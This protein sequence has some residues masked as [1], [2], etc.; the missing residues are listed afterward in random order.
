MSFFLPEG[1][2]V[3]GFASL[4]QG[5]HL[6]VEFALSSH[7][8]LHEKAGLLDPDSQILVRKPFPR[9]PLLQGLVIDDFF[10]ISAE[11]P[12]SDVSA[13]K[14]VEA[15]KIAKQ[16]Y[17]RENLL[18]SDEKDL[19]SSDHFQVT[20]AEVNSSHKNRSQHLVSVSAP[21]GKRLALAALSLRVASFPG[22]SISLASRLAGNSTSVLL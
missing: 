6:G 4:F 5:D 16:A 1:H 15:W 12:L 21:T 2:V 11:H 9:G 10:T 14:S 22:I 7:Q 13:A 20:G 8:A 3:A 18:G 17:K 19:I